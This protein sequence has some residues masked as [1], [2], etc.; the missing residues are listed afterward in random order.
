MRL[1]V[2]APTAF[3]PERALADGPGWL[4]ERADAGVAAASL[5]GLPSQADEAWKYLDIDIDLSTLTGGDPSGEPFPDGAF[6]KSIANRAGTMTVVDGRP[7]SVVANDSEAVLMS[8]EQAMS[9]H[10]EVLAKTYLASTAAD[11]DLFSALHHAAAPDGVFLLLPAGFADERPFVIDLQGTAENAMT[12]PHVTIVAERASQASVII[13]TRSGAGTRVV[14]PQIET[15]VGDGA[16]LSITRAQHWGDQTTEFG[17]HRILSGRDATVRLADIGLGGATSRLDL[18]V[19]LEGRG[20][21]FEMMGAYFGDREQVM[22]YRV[23]IN[24]RAPNTSSNVFLKGAV[25]DSA[26][27]V[28]SGLLK[29]F[30]NASKVSAFETNRNLVLSENAKAHSVP[31]LEILC[32]DIICGHGSTVGPLETDHVYYLQSRGLPRDRA[33][34]LLVRGFFEEIIQAIPHEL[35]EPTRVAL[36]SKFVAAQEEGRL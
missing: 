18:T 17:Y 3:L 34:R 26:E 29:I 4:E 19:D 15:T 22:D 1:A 30:P 5:L 24:H 8:L 2:P 20:G 35:A 31:N 27:S 7:R 36:N 28:F 9:S 12:F 16:N 32:D 14:V 11:R 21:S 33:E 23:V 13:N 25:E 10:E 6:L